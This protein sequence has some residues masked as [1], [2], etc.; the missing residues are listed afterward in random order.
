MESTITDCRNF[1]KE[2][3]KYLIPAVGKT[4]NTYLR[5]F[6]DASITATREHRAYG[7]FSMGALSTWYQIAFDPAVA[8]YY[9]PLS[10]DLWVYDENQPKVFHR[11]GS[12][13]A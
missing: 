4:Y 13:M 10:G 3:R 7:G 6:D 1:H 8:K 12:Y 9:L 2:L 5:T 11:K